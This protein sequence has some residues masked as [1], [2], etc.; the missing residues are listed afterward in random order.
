MDYMDT[1]PNRELELKKLALEI[2][3]LERPWW[4]RPAYI[5]AAL[6]TLL[7][8][9]AL[10]VGFLNGFFSAQLTKLDNQKFA[11]EQQIKEFES[12][13]DQLHQQNDQLSAQLENLKKEIAIKDAIAAAIPDQQVKKRIMELALKDKDF[14]KCMDQNAILHLFK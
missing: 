4:R 8:V 3:E 1:D 5:L 7:A 6:P 14:G 2:A 12:R 13:R 10:S 9:A 11:L